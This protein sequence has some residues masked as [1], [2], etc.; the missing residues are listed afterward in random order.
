MPI[1][2]PNTANTLSIMFR[3]GEDLRNPPTASQSVF[4]HGNYRMERSYGDDFLSGHTNGLRFDG[5]ESIESM[6]MS[7]VTEVDTTFVHADELRLIDRDATS[8]VYFGSLRME[9]LVAMNNIIDNWPYAVM[10]RN[11]EQDGTLGTGLTM[12]DYSA[13]TAQQAGLTIGVSDFK[14]PYSA[15]TNMG[16]VILTSGSTRQ[17][18]SLLM[19]TQ[20]FVIQLSGQSAV[21][22]IV[23]YSF[24]AGDYLQ[25]RVAGNP[26][27]SFSI[28]SSTSNLYIRPNKKVVHNFE[29]S[30]S[31]LERHI[32]YNGRW[33]MPNQQFDNGSTIEVSYTWPRTVDGYN[34]D[35]FGSAFEAYRNNVLDFSEKMDSEKTDVLMRSVIPENYLELDSDQSVY[36]NIVQAYAHQFDIIKRYVDSIAFGH[37]VTYDKENNI[38]DKFLFKLTELLGLRLPNGFNEMDLFSYMSSS[39]D[40]EGDSVQAYI[41]EVWKRIMVNLV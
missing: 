33:L 36:R 2:L 7:G 22:E 20:D 10:A 9:T 24:S 12:Y 19:D 13:S 3:P 14:V 39:L 4:T 40:E 18:R 23:S 11:F 25:F 16:G 28:S 37:T 34:P 21:Y 5:Y 41:L 6:N 15:I 17:G 1:G 31:P 30:L 35:V 27:E 38:P 32:L 29:S 26:L 8:Y